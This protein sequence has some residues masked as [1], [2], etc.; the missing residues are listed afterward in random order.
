MGVVQQQCPLGLSNDLQYKNIKT[1]SKM[2]SYVFFCVVLC[3]AFFFYYY[4]SVY[5]L[6]VNVYCT[7]AIGCQPNCS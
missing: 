2:S 5:C 7:T 6:C 3:I 1:I 4:Y